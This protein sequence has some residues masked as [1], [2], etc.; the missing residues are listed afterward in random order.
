MAL[1]EA[2]PRVKGNAHVFAG[3]KDRPL[4]EIA[5]IWYAVRHAA[6]LDDVRL[7]DL[8]HSFASV[9]AS[10]GGSLLMIGSLLGHK[11][12][13]TTKRYAHLFDDPVKAAA[14]A[15]STQLSDWLTRKS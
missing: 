2:L 13:S 4:I 7:H 6:G 5:R 10:A 9:V 12:S 11:Q 8:R 3:K 15:T 14:D 1:L